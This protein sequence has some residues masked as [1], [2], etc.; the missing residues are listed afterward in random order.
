MV[1]GIYFVICE[2][3]VIS[4]ISKILFPF[5]TKSALST[6]GLPSTFSLV[7]FLGLTEILLG[8][9]GILVGG[10]YFPIMTGALFA[11]FSVFILFA[12]RNGQV[13][14]CGCFGAT[15]SPPSVMHLFANLTFMTIA[16]LAI[17]VDGLSSVLGE[18][19]GKGIPFVIAV[20]LGALATYLIMSFAPRI[21]NRREAT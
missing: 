2:V 14:S 21:W 10:K 1:A 16:L 4:G 9:L 8:I 12:L 18:Q 20:L 11:F 5:P 3:L 19:P 6:V 13:T 7:R 15:T 17:G